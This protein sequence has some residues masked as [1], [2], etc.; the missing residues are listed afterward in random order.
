MKY[1]LILSLMILAGCTPSATEIVWPVV[2]DG[3]KD[4]KFYKLKDTKGNTL[5]I[6][7]CPLSATTVETQIDRQTKRPGTTI[8]VDSSTN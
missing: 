2:P 5:S 1:T 4:C 7:R 6:A 8:A 3:L